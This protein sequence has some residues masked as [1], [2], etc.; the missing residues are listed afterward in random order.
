[1]KLEYSTGRKK[2]RDYF[3]SKIISFFV[4]LSLLLVFI[5]VSGCQASYKPIT[6]VTSYGEIERGYSMAEVMVVLGN[7]S[8]ISISPRDNTEIWYYDLVEETTLVYFLSKQVVKVVSLEDAFPTLLGDIQRG[9]HKEEI[10]EMLGEPYQK[11]LGKDVDIWCYPL[12]EGGRLFIFFRDDNVSSV[13]Q[14]KLP[15]K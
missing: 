1:M 15:S 6:F 8:D 9:A 13:W 12:D 2:S 5:M 11:S 14:K 3:M 7:P 10:E 4:F